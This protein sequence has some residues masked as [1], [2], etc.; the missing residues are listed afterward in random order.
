MICHSYIKSKHIRRE[1]ASN[2]TIIKKLISYK[3]HPSNTGLP[4]CVDQ[5]S[6]LSL[7]IWDEFLLVKK[8]CREIINVK[9]FIWW[10]LDI[11]FTNVFALEI[12]TDRFICVMGMVTNCLK[13]QRALYNTLRSYH[14]FHIVRLKHFAPALA[15]L[16][17]ILE[18]WLYFQNV[19]HVNEYY[20]IS[21]PKST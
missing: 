9:W 2:V 3:Y 16:T 6:I 11:Y 14:K 12:N 7:Q 1:S 5:I 4:V 21:C 8:L 10:V 18:R 15:Y 17:L 13:S 20:I 19:L